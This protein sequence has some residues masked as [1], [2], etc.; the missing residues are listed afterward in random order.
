MNRRNFLLHA[1]GYSATAV[2]P[3]AAYAHLVEP[4]T[5]QVR[6]LR[7]ELKGLRTERPIRLLHLSDLHASP[8]VPNSLI[9]AAIGL[10]LELKPDFA[11][12]TGDFVTHQG[13]WNPDWFRGALRRMTSKV[14]TFGSLGNHDGGWSG[15]GMKDSETVQKVVVSG[16][17]ELLHNRHATLP[18]AGGHVELVGLGDL[19]GHEF[20]PQRAFPREKG[21]VPR[22]VLSHNPDT[23]DLLAQRPWDLMLSG[24]THGGQVVL[25]LVGAPWAPVTDQRYLHGLKPWGGRQIH[26]TAG[27][28]SAMGVRLN[29]PPEVVLLEL[30]GTGNPT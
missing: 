6:H 15:S 11:C 28:G 5:L 22:I 9:E 24:H 13:G 23:K 17:V 8:E 20:L 25:P 12:I 14:Q 26:V 18:V 16:G 7:C 4:I 10:G 2:V 29:C 21:H 30:T 1:V 3:V 27:V 19:W